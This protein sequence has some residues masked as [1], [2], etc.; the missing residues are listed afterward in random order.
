MR[1]VPP[2]S[3]ILRAS[4]QDANGLALTEQIPVTVDADT[5][6]V[7]LQ[8]QPAVSIPVI[9]RTESTAAASPGDLA[10]P[11]VHA[12]KNTGVSVHL[13]S[14]GTPPLVFFSYLEGKPENPQLILRNVQAGKYATRVT[15]V[16]PWYV[17][18]V[19]SGGQDLLQEDLVSGPGGSTE[20][21]NVVLRDDS[22]SITGTVQAGNNTAQALVLLVPTGRV[23][24]EPMIQ[25]VNFASR[26]Q[27]VQFQPVQFHFSGL[28]PGEYDLFA[29]DQVEGLEYAN[30]E[31]LQPYSGHAVRVSV[32]PGESKSVSPELIVR[33]SQ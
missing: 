11:G 27:P 18:A 17:D 32:H 12:G 15:A 13:E 20:P 29:F 14:R 10:P 22:G 24:A 25:S 31:A 6:G 19:T 30:P 1:A 7:R 21:I 9:V 16:G 26:L 28:A 8:V 3:Y 4:T 23:S 33:G 5:T 2:G